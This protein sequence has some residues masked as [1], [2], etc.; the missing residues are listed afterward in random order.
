MAGELLLFLSVVTAS[1][2]NLNPDFQFSALNPA[3]EG[4][5]GVVRIYKSP[6]AE[7]H[8]K[9]TPITESA[10]AERALEVSYG[11]I[12]GLYQPKKNPYAGEVTALVQCDHKFAP[13]EFKVKCGSKMAKA[14]AGGAG[15]RHAFGMCT[16]KD[17]REI[18]IFF[19]CYDEKRKELLEVRLFL[20]FDKSKA[21]KAQLSA[22]E[23]F[24]AGLLQ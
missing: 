24:A 19:S 8:L 12:K 3:L 6:S 23:K 21:W 22:A 2:Q 10:S 11:L 14:I 13:R 5:P 20:P 9:S 16:A 17:I 7:A 15:E 18:G 1:A 4:K